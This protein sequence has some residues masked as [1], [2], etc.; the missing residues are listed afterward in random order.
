MGMGTIIEMAA[1]VE[2]VTGNP[3]LCG[4]LG[5]VSEVFWNKKKEERHTS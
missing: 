1:T 5:E 3:R 2:M 4:H